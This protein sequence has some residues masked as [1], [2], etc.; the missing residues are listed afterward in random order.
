HNPL[1]YLIKG[2][3]GTF[4]G[5]GTQFN[6]FVDAKTAVAN[7]VQLQV[8]YD[9]NGSGTFGRTETY[10]YFATDNVT[11]FQSYTPSAGLESSSGSLGNLSNGTIEIKVWNAIGNNPS[12][13]NV[14]AASAQGSQSVIVLPFTNLT[15]STGGGG[16]GGGGG[17]SGPVSIN[18]GGAA[19]GSFVADTGFSGGSTTSTSVA[20]NVSLIPA[21]VPPQAVYQTGRTGV[22]TY[23]LG[24][25]TAGSSH[26]VQLHFAEIVF[27]A[28]RQRMFNILINGVTVLSNFDIFANAGGANKA[29]EENFTTTANS[30]GQIVIQFTSGSAATPLIN[31]IVVQ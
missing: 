16:G 3:T 13:L 20:I 12:F 10:H 15:T 18:A 24:G 29:I 28:S 23:T 25:F 5:G 30:S 17:T 1:I 22:S 2:V 27:T 11:G 6:L 26:Q 4:S 31:A 14:G 7:G 8:L 19:T 9:L 21:P